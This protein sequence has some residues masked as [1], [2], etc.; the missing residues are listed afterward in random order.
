MDVVPTFRFIASLIA[1]GLLM[2]VYEPVVDYL[3]SICGTPA[4]A[5]TSVI[6]FLWGALAAI[7]LLASGIKLIME[8]QRRQGGFF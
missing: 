8:V 2:F 3:V 6:F 1:F 4:Y 5:M 7:N